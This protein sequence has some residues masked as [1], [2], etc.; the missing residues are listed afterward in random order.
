[1]TAKYLIA[2]LAISFGTAAIATPELPRHADLDLKTA[3]LLADAGVS[4]LKL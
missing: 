2:S 4:I 1:M 3:R